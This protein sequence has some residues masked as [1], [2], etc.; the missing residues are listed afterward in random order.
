MESWAG[1]GGGAARFNRPEKRQMNTASKVIIAAIHRNDV[2]ML[3]NETSRPATASAAEPPFS[4]TP[5]WSISI[6]PR[7]GAMTVPRE[8]NACEKVSLKCDRSDDP[9]TA[10]R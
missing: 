4:N 5:P 10:A 8:L 9:N 7:Y 2:S 1:A 3:R 6:E